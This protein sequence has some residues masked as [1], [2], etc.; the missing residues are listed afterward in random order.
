MNPSATIAAALVLALQG[1]TASAAVPTPATAPVAAPAAPAASRPAPAG[2]RT[3]PAR[4][5]TLPVGA[6]TL[7]A[8]WLEAVEPGLSKAVRSSPPPAA[9]P[10]PAAR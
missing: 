6:E 3:V 7:P 1:A 9:S 5:A 2:V 10:R 8:D 4:T